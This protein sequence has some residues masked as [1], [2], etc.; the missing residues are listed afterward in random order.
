[1]EIVARAFDREGQRLIENIH[2]PVHNGFFCSIGGYLLD[3]RFVIT[4]WTNLCDKDGIKIFNGDIIE[5]ESD[6]ALS[7]GSTRVRALVGFKDGCYMYSAGQDRNNFN[8]LLYPVVSKCK[9][10]GNKFLNEPALWSLAIIKKP[11]KTK[12]KNAG[13]KKSKLGS[14]KTTTKKRISVKGNNKL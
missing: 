12:N 7:I 3:P 5:I 1:M 4:L 2:L 14:R 10:I 9:V 6:A 11:R 8:T 13:K